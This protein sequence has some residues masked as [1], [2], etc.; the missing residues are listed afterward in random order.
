MKHFLLICFAVFVFYSHNT[1]AQIPTNILVQIVK[2]E[3]ERRFDNTLENFLT[4]PTE[5]IRTRAALAAGRIGD[6][7]SLPA[8]TKL[9]QTD[10]STKVRAMAAFAMGEIESAKAA[11]AI[12]EVLNNRGNPNEIR[13]RAMEAAGKIAAANTKDEK[14]KELGDT[15]LQARDFENKKRSASNKEVILFG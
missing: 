2:A 1:F 5:K 11:P 13:A 12:I 8:L 15:I 4:N 6:E 3:D 9:L 7:R 14:Y 10:P